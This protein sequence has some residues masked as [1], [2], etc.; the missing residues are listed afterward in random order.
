MTIE[1]SG[2]AK[3]E[4]PWKGLAIGTGLLA[5]V[6][7]LGAMLS[8]AGRAAPG[9]VVESGEGEGEGEP[10]RTDR[11]VGSGSGG[12]NGV[13]GDRSPGGRMSVPPFILY[14]EETHETGI[15]HGPQVVELVRESRSKPGRWFVHTADRADGWMDLP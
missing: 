7:A 8:R 2:A 15:S 6:V 11:T 5:A 1:A 10:G 3:S 14:Y 4:I 12:G 13:L 9:S